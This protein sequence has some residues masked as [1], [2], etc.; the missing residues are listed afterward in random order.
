MSLQLVSSHIFAVGCND[1]VLVYDVATLC[2][3]ATTASVLVRGA[4]LN[5]S[6]DQEQAPHSFFKNNDDSTPD[7]R[8]NQHLGLHLASNPT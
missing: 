7:L 2:R 5:F 3:S 6:R 1:I 8:S 4:A